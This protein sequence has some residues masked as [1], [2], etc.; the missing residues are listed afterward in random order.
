MPIKIPDNLPASKILKEENIFV[1]N[2]TRATTQ[3]IRPL[4]LLILNIMPTKIIT[5]TQLLRL[6]SNSPL[7]I[8]VDWIHM[9]SHESKNVSKEHLLAFYKTFDEAKGEYFDGFIITGAPVE[10]MEFEEVDYWNE[11]EEIMDYSKRKTKSTLYICWAAQASLYKYYNVKKL[12][13][14]QKCFGVFK[15]KVDKDSKI[16]DG[17]ENEFFAPHSRHTTVNI[18]ALKENKELS[19]VSHS[20]EAG[21]YIITN[22]RD[23]FVMGHSEYDKYTLDKEYKRDIN[24]GDKISIPQNYYINDD[25]S[26]EPTVKWK[27]HSELLF[28]NW[29]KNYLIQ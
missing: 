4:K 23:V 27:K 8:E 19:I 24:K 11:L 7:Q 25:P 10:Q 3:K 5:E 6:L 15:H 1:M 12:P 21:P 13:L 2:E 26:E 29:I 14:S 16:V 18:E 20:K 28:R 22:S 17:F 9:A